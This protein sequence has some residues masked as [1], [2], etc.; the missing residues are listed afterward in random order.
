MKTFLPEKERDKSWHKTD[1]THKQCTDALLLKNKYKVCYLHTCISALPSSSW[2]NMTSDVCIIVSYANIVSNTASSLA[3]VHVI[4]LTWTNMCLLTSL[5]TFGPR[6]EQSHIFHQHLDGGVFFL[7]ESVL[8][9]KSDRSDWLGDY[10]YMDISNLIIY[11]IL[12]KFIL[13]LRCL[14]E[15]LSCSSFT[16]YI[17]RM[18]HVITT[19]SGVPS[20]ISCIDI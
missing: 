7:N 1:I 14:H 15:L 4:G 9:N 17:D 18:V 10:V 19:S 8:L 13:W 3:A 2:I 20:R 16:C 12:N 5:K 6:H 11:A